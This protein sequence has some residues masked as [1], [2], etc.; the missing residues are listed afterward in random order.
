MFGAVRL[1]NGGGSNQWLFTGEQRDADGLYFLRARYYDPASGRFLGRDPLTLGHPY[2][3]VGSNPV[4]LI[5]PYGLAACDLGP[6]DPCE[7]VENAGECIA[8]GLDCLPDWLTDAFTGGSLVQ[9]LI[10]IGDILPLSV[11]CAVVGA[12]LG[13]IAGSAAGG[14]GAVP[15]ALGG[16]K[17]GYVV[18]EVAE[19]LIGLIATYNSAI[20]IANSHCSKEAQLG[21]AAL[22]VVNFFVDVPNSGQGEV[23]EKAAEI[24]GYAASNE[25]LTCKE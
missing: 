17:T 9:N 24:G 21:A 23:I 16:A 3:Y 15:G 12:I 14:V 20:Q 22:L 18:C 11:G 5:D 4:N 10:T 25:L 7:E 19:D 2:S 13:G 8:N 1:Q 6:V